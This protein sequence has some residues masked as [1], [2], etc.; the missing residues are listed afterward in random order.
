MTAL[1]LA[2]ACFCCILC[3]SVWWLIALAREAGPAAAG[4][5][6]TLIFALWLG[7]LLLAHWSDTKR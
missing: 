3:L 4:L 5:Y 7:A 2:V 1:N 6:G